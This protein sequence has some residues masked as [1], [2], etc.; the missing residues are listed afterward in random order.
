MGDGNGN[1]VPVHAMKAYKWV[2][3][4]LDSIYETDRRERK[5]F[6]HEPLYAREEK[7]W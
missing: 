3:V 1:A 7:T 2:E 6:T 4:Y 5:N